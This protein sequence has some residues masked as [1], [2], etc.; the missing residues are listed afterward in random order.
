MTSTDP[1]AAIDERKART[2]LGRRLEELRTAIVSSGTRLLTWDE[3]ECE[4][5]ER[6]GERSPSDYG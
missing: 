3:L 5:S 1:R 2:P 4:V 6:R